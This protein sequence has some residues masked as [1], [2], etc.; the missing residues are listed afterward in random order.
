MD[1]SSSPF[2]AFSSQADALGHAEH[3][4]KPDSE[5]LAAYQGGET[6]LEERLGREASVG[7]TYSSSVSGSW[8]GMA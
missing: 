4:T 1:L 5:A 2:G 3:A 7:K 6:S 8:A